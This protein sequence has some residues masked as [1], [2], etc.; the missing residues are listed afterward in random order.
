MKNKF[1][2]KWTL[3]FLTIIHF[4]NSSNGYAQNGI[5]NSL[6]A[7]AFIKSYWIILNKLRQQSFL[8]FIK[9]ENSEEYLKRKRRI[10]ILSFFRAV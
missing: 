2:I 7:T 10:K 6:E 4:S 8:E 3:L 1:F 9:S 5:K